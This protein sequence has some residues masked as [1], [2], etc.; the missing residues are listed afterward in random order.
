MLYL[1]KVLAQLAYPLGL[2]LSLCLLALL[3]LG[4]RW[5][6]LATAALVVA[7]G[8]LGVWS[9][10]A[11]SDALRL[12]LEDRFPKV[13]V[14]A[15]PE[16][17]AVVVLGGGIRSGT[18]DWPYPDLG[19]AADRAWHAAR[20][21]HAGKAPVIVISGG[22]IP[23]L[24]DVATEAEAMQEF[25]S[26]LG[27]PSDAVLLEDRSRSTYENAV[28]TAEFLR[29]WGFGEVL[30]VT[31]A[32][33]MPRALPTFR[34][35]GVN[36]IPAPTDFEVRPVPNQ[37]LRWL[38]DSDALRDSTRAIKEYLGLWVYRWRGWAV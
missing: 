32:L 8:W 33:H 7:V 14:S 1:D 12:S 38:P 11:V 24:G 17:D 23:W 20:I 25:L 9:L 10:P 36:A 34:A 35:A 13:L 37:P 28:F 30:L 19:N 3:L 5:R 6:R 4:L 2:S 22:S 29:D 18:P 31:S 15:L 21:F 26:D 27:V 16:A